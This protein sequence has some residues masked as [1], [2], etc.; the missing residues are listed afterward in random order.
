MLRWR[1]SAKAR[2]KLAGYSFDCHEAWAVATGTITSEKTAAAAGGAGQTARFCHSCL[3]WLGG[4]GRFDCETSDL[5]L[6]RMAS[7]NHD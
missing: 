3:G 7:I 1:K 2:A 4:N 6:V 5:S